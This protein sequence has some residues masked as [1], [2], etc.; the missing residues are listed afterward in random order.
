MTD[1]VDGLRPHCW[2]L[3]AHRQRRDADPAQPPL[4]LSPVNWHALPSVNCFHAAFLD[5]FQRHLRRLRVRQILQ[6]HQGILQAC[7]PKMLRLQTSQTE[8]LRGTKIVALYST[9]SIC[10]ADLTY[11]PVMKCWTG[12][13]AFHSK[14]WQKKPTQL[15]PNP[16]FSLL[17]VSSART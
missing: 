5:G 6:L 16:C 13:D 3:D 14:H 7:R 1:L 4:P 9:P 17:T 2:W 11:R 8:M 10:R 12:P 15:R